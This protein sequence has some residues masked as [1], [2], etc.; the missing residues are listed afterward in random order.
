MYWYKSKI[1]FLSLLGAGIFISLVSS[2]KPDV[3]DTNLKYFDLDGYFKNEATRL[4]KANMLINKSVTHNGT[5]E[6][7]KL[8][9]SNWDTELSLFKASDINRPAWKKSYS[10]LKD[11]DIIIYKALEPELTTREILIKLADGK[12]KYMMIINDTHNMIYTTREKLS[13]FPD[14]LYLIQKSQKV[15]FLG[16]NNY[17][18][19]GSFN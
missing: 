4:T 9:I 12:V 17:D 3:R 15:R 6:T 10:I 2:C 8:H 16:V 18:I 14:S 5:T 13:Y 1:N 11:S 7:K 19:R